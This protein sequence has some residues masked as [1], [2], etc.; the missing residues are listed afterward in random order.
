MADHFSGSGKGVRRGHDEVASLHTGSLQRQMHRGGTGI[1]R[2][3]KFCSEIVGKALFELMGLG[4]GCDPA[5]LQDLLD[6]T[7]FGL[8][9]FW[10]GER[11]GGRSLHDPD[12]SDRFTRVERSSLMLPTADRF[13]ESRI[14]A[15][16]S[17]VSRV[18]IQALTALLFPLG[19]S[20]VTNQL[21]EIS[22][23]GGR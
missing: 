20:E 23:V 16:G 4:A 11:K 10:Q 9:N 15:S 2:D 6:L 19:V 7:Q 8:T 1:D 13:N 5:G 12:Q 18:R 17:P 14:S 22:S 21:V 3:S